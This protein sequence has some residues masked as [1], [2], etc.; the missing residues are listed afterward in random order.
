MRFNDYIFAFDFDGT[1]VKSTHFENIE[2]NRQNFKEFKMFLNP[3][4]FELNWAIVTSRPKTDIKLLK[5][6]LERNQAVNFKALLTQPYDIPVTKCDEEYTI[7]ARNLFKL[8]KDTQKR[9]VYV[10]NS[11]HVRLMVRKA[12][13]DQNRDNDFLF[14]DTVT[15][16]NHFVKGEFD[17]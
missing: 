1:L 7:K 9:V 3:D 12:C 5:E 14:K 11:E 4:A 15:L 16:F 6:C 2:K 13:Y 10:D 8:H 17:K